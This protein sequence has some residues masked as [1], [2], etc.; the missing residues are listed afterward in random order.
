VPLI[1]T[2]EIVTLVPPV[3]VIVSESDG[4]L[5]TVTLPKLRLVG[6]APSAPVVTPVPDRAIVRD[7]SEAFELMVTV[8]LALPEA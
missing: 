8:P 5:P 4:S 6:L 1:A 7:E 3:L 2:E